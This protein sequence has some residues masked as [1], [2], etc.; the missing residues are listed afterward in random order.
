MTAHC[1]DCAAA[2][3]EI[4]HYGE[5][6][7]GC[8]DCNVWRSNKRAFIVE[9]SPEDIRALRELEVNGRLVRGGVARRGIDGKET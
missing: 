7:I 6:L 8:I 4:D 2:L 5:R 9:L 1:E 3:V